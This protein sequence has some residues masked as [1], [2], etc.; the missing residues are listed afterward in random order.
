MLQSILA[1]VV[2]FGIIV[3]IHETGHFLFAKKFGVLV[4]EFAI[5]FG[6]KIFQTHR[7]ETTYTVR[8]LPL[9]GY[10][11]LAGDE[12]EED[13]RPGMFV[14]LDLNEQEKVRKI[15]LSSEYTHSKGL[16]FE[17]EQFDLVDDLV[18]TGHIPNSDR[19]ES[20][21]VDEKALI[22]REDGTM[23]QIAPRE[24]Q[25]TSAPVWQ[26]ML[27]NLAGPL[28][29]FLLSI[30]VFTIFAFAQGGIPSSEPI[31]GKFEPDSPVAQSDFQPGDQI[32]SVGGKSVSSWTEMVIEI[33]KH[34]GEAVQLVG[35]RADGETITDT[36]TPE[37]AEDKNG[38]VY[39]R[40]GVH[41]HM[42]TDLGS[43]LK[44]GFVRTVEVIRMVVQS[45][46]RIV[47]GSLGMDQL[48]GPLAIFATT[49]EVARLGGV[50]GIIS[51]IG[52]L[53]ANIGLMNLLPIPG[54][55]GGK[56]FLNLIEAVRGKPISQEKETMITMIGVVLLLALMLFV[57]WQDLTRYFFK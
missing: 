30:V 21:Q 16:P 1:F 40:I 53:S 33:Q 37:K 19:L 34:P 38:K 6:P 11:M 23:I 43:K 3:F 17:V 41:V 5:G 57:T 4:R 14:H 48:G 44:F 42:E 28:F 27:I 18:I 31:L 24:R 54:L 12:E 55:D 45:L 10:V 51:F 39:G 46:R 32:E 35:K 49:G 50:I 9:G 20:Y 29:N 47:T 25:V 56:L 2:V 52:F 36:V 22:V 13:L 7:D 8:A 15:Y 26:R